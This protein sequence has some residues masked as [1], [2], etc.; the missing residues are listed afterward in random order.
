M[1]A[2]IL[3][4]A[5]LEDYFHCL[6]HWMNPSM[7]QAVKVAEIHSPQTVAQET[8]SLF[9]TSANKT[10][11]LKECIEDMDDTHI[12]KR[13]LISLCETRFLKCHTVVVTSRQLF[14][15]A[16][17]ALQEIKTWNSATAVWS[18]SSLYASMHQFAFVVGWV[19]RKQQAVK[20][21][22]MEATSIV[23]SGEHARSEAGF[24]KTFAKASFL[25]EHHGIVVSSQRLSK[26]RSVYRPTTRVKG[27]YFICYNFS[28]RLHR[29]PWEFH[30]F[31]RFREFPSIP[32]FSRFV[33]ILYR[34]SKSNNVEQTLAYSLPNS[35]ALVA[36]SKGMPAEKLRSNK[37]LQF[38][39]VGAG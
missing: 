9:R 26:G 21:N 1:A 6:A 36:V 10:S 23:G 13:Q 35:N 34:D 14:G 3:H 25:A 11:A 7:L 37:I 38:L 28:L 29:I 4:Q 39:T 32:G 5:D 20:N 19:S 2:Q 12:T 31:S 8:A 16:A 24:Q 18:A 30:E 15:F 17:E 33:A 22:L 27:D